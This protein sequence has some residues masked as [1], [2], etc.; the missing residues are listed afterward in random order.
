[1]RVENIADTLASLRINSISDQ[2]DQLRQI[3]QEIR[4]EGNDI[5]SLRD[6]AARALPILLQLF[7]ALGT[8][9]GAR[10]II[11]GATTGIL[12]AG[13]WP[14]AVIFTV[15]MAAWHGKDAFMAALGK[16]PKNSADGE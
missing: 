3:S 10:I 9:E 15:A 6:V 16:L 12:G 8:Q 13:G 4:A 14:S 11:S 5:P 1:L 7:D 2:V